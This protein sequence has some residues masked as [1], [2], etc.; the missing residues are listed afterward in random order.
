M[1]IYLGGVTV[2]DCKLT[3]RVQVIVQVIVA[4]SPVQYSGSL[5]RSASIGAW[6]QAGVFWG[7]NVLFKGLLRPAE[8]TKS[9]QKM[10]AGRLKA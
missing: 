1:G 6:T 3:M 7:A 9:C 2:Y 4:T 5:S 10:Q 8:C